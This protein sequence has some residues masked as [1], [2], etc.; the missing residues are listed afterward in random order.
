MADK[1]PRDSKSC[2]GPAAADGLA[3]VA[4]KRARTGHVV[5]NIGGVRFETTVNTLCSFSDSFFAKMFGGTYDTRT[6]PDGSYFIDRSG[7][8]FG[9]VLNFMR[10]HRVRV[11]GAAADPGGHCG[12]ARGDGILSARWAVSRRLPR[13]SRLHSA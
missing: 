12:A 11:G 3:E 10:T 5:L 13:R 6:E 9:Q 7:E 2:T 1:R 4:E 8:H